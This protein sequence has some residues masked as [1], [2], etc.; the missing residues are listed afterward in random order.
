ML[1]QISI[2]NTTSA[3]P[4]NNLTLATVAQESV[5]GGA[6]EVIRVRFSMRYSGDAT[7]PNRIQ[8]VPAVFV[9]RRL[10]LLALYNGSRPWKDEPISYLVPGER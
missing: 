4:S 10:G 8:E 7:M 9:D 2:L 5:A 1:S 3:F 6:L